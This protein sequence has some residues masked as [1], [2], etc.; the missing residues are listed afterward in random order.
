MRA[1]GLFRRYLKVR[2]FRKRLGVASRRVEVRTRWPFR[3]RLLV[4]CLGGVA[5]V[6]VLVVLA[7]T[8]GRYS[9][10]AERCNVVMS[11]PVL[12]PRWVRGG[13]VEAAALEGGVRQQLL[14]R[15]ENLE[16]E[17]AALKDDV[18]MFERLV[19]L[20]AGEASVRIGGF[21]VRRVGE[22]H[23][24]YHLLFAYGA[25]RPGQGFKGALQLLVVYRR[26]GGDDSLLLPDG[27]D[28][29]GYSLE[30]RHFVRHEGEFSLPVGAQL[31]SV[32]ARVLQGGVIRAREIV[33][34]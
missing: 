26:G 15:I 30:I 1:R 12:L 34:L 4:W 14:Q 25:E 7:L 11:E 19:P 17:N 3:W 20:D 6:G 23:Y 13:G 18:R 5:T 28:I 2:K 16:R 9:D 33:S 22:G 8:L 27:R 29:G 32:E 10:A 24:R 21:R 31:K